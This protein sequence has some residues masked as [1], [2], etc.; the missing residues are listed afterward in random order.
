MIYQEQFC[1]LWCVYIA[2]V[3]AVPVGIVLADLFYSY[4]G[5]L[6]MKKATWVPET[7]FHF[8]EVSLFWMISQEHRADLSMLW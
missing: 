6:K 7:E 2:R 5:Q 4:A 3:T 1:L 8:K